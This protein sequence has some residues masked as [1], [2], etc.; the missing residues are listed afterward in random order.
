MTHL[1]AAATHSGHGPLWLLAIAGGILIM[2]VLGIRR[3]RAQCRSLFPPLRFWI[4][5][6]AIAGGVAWVNR[7]YAPWQHNTD[8]PFL[9]AALAGFSAL[10]SALITGVTVSRGRRNYD[11][12]T[13]AGGR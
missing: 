8:K 5:T 4:L 10:I 6:A 13:P 7:D 2:M 3:A 9:Y 1:T 12:G 11:R